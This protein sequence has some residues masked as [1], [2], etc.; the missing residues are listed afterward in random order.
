LVQGEDDWYAIL[1]VVLPAAAVAISAFV[2]YVVANRSW[3][4]GKS[5]QYAASMLVEERKALDDLNDFLDPYMEWLHQVVALFPFIHSEWQTHMEEGN[6][7]G[8]GLQPFDQFWQQATQICEAV[9]SSSSEVWQVR[10]AL[11]LLPLEKPVTDSVTLLAFI[12]R[13]HARLWNAHIDRV[14]KIQQVE[15][16]DLTVLENG[17]KAM[18]EWLQ[19]LEEVEGVSWEWLNDKQ[20][21]GQP[22]K[23][24]INLEALK[25]LVE[26]DGK[27]GLKK[28]AT[29]PWTP[30]I[31]PQG[32]GRT[33]TG[34][35]TLEWDLSHEE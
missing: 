26:K 12:F 35:V 16:E 7:Y 27:W 17:F 34:T 9:P 19:F 28:Q 21:E 20:A 6:R 31:H 25:F 11:R 29:P 1:V 8:P 24:V 22:L 2:S 3:K 5:V 15:P 10:R 13:S 14:H 4:K 33:A 23:H 30:Y 18:K 32:V